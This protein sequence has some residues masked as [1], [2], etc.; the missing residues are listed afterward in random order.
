M[1]GREGLEASKP[2]PN[3]NGVERTYCLVVVVVF[4]S[5]ASLISMTERPRDPT[6]QMVVISLFWCLLALTPIGVTM[7][8]LYRRRQVHGEMI[9]CILI[10]VAMWMLF[11]AMLFPDC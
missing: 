3:I 1:A 10:T 9:F 5:M 11:G 7:E 2:T 8:L 6:I 4:V